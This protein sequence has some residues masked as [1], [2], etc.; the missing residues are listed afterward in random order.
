MRLGTLLLTAGLA[1]AAIPQEEYKVRRAALRQA[2]PEGAVVVLQGSTESEKGDLRTPFIQEP[3]FL[4]LTGWRE[5]G[6]ALVLTKTGEEFYLPK[7]SEVRERYTGHKLAPGDSDATSV[8]GFETVL[9]SDDFA[10]RV[11][12]TTGT[13]YVLSKTGSA[14]KVKQAA[15]GRD[16]AD[17]APLIAHLRMTKS[18]AEV[19]ALQFAVDSS[20]EAHKAG[21]RRAAPGIAEYQIAATMSAVYFERGCERH[22]YPPI[23]ASGPNAVTL[24]YSANKRRMDAGE[25][26]LMDVGAECADYAADIT[27]TIPVNGKFSA[28]QREIYDIVL[29]AQKAAIAAA[30]PGMR[31]LG[32]E[33]DSLNGIAYR[34]VNSHGK[35]QKGEPLGKYYLHSL[36]HHVGLEVH[37]AFD[38]DL[39]LQPGMVVTIEPG[40]YLAGERIGV[41]I[42]DMILITES[43]A[44]LLTEALPREA[45][46][47]ERFLARREKRA[48][49]ATN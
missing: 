30:K 14:E 10:D 5:P 9:A 24:H 2:L 22:A 13:L 28:R 12:K 44:K 6:A 19:E 36:G 17:A 49:P 32:L 45:K 11:A 16:F 40:I 42:E 7:R 37:D 29:G 18:S 39:R 33:E 23:V 46:E 15:P 25:L 1:A 48:R 3:N 26:L 21:M 47:I 4:Y 8:T 27:R 38:P 31:L 34:Y 35:D 43:G 20:V 41:R